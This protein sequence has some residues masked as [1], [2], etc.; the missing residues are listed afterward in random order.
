M[1]GSP[2]GKGCIPQQG[3]AS[4]NT[5]EVAGSTAQAGKPV[6]MVPLY[7]LEHCVVLCTHAYVPANI[8][9]GSV[10]RYAGIGTEVGF[11]PGGGGQRTENETTVMMVDWVL[12]GGQYLHQQMGI[13]GAQ[14]AKKGRVRGMYNA[15]IHT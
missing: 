15:S 1:L 6:S 10:S 7:E 5:C 13:S 2:A 4:G 14:R 9:F 11:L 12:G 3:S 8:H